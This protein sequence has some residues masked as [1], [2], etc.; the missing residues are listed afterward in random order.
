MLKKQA[1]WYSYPQGM[2]TYTQGEA[3]NVDNL[4]ITDTAPTPFAE[5]FPL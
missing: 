3:E 4:L 1:K 5:N 2:G